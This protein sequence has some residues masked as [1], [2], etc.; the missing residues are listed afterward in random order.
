MYCIYVLI[1]NWIFTLFFS[2]ETCQHSVPYTHFSV[3]DYFVFFTEI[4][5][6]LSF[7]YNCNTLNL[8][9]IT[10]TAEVIATYIRFPFGFNQFYGYF[11]TKC[12]PANIV[13]D[14]AISVPIIPWTQFKT[15]PVFIV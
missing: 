11:P 6:L 12:K 8:D 10:T 2:S 15:K 7:I 3:T 1:W 14:F 9:A 5:Y 13:I 4:L